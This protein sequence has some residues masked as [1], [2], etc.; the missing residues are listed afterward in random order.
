MMYYPEM[1]QQAEP[2]LFKTRYNYGDSYSC[3]WAPESNDAALAQLKA[4][5]IKA[6][7]LQFD[8]PGIELVPNAKARWSCLI[9]SKSHTKLFDADLCAHEQ[10]LD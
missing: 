4:M 3:Q 10:L 7:Y 9:T 6:K 2:R 8:R 1:G 5:R